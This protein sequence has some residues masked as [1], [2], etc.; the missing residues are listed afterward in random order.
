MGRCLVWH[1]YNRRRLCQFKFGN[2]RKGPARESR[3]ITYSHRFVKGFLHS[4]NVV[5]VGAEEHKT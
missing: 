5:L 1:C 4:G 2:E 3:P